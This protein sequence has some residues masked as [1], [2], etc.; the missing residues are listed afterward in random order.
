MGSQRANS[1]LG[2]RLG[3]EIGNGNAGSAFGQCQRDGATDAFGR[4]GDEHG[5]SLEQLIHKKIKK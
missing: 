1:L 4:S 3:G 5:F 2:L